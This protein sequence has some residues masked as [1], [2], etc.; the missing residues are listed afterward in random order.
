MN[1]IF[2]VLLFL[3]FSY[4][5]EAQFNLKYREATIFFRDGTQKKGLGKLAKLGSKIKFKET[6]KGEVIIY[7]Y[8]KLS[9][10]TIE[11]SYNPIEFEYKII[12]GKTGV[13]LLRVKKRG[14]LDLYYIIGRTPVMGGADGIT[15]G[16]ESYDI[17]YI[18]KSNDS[19]VYPTDVSKKKFKKLIDIFFKDCPKLIA[20]I[21]NKE[22]K[23]HKI[24]EIVEFYN[25]K[26]K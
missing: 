20:K 15:Y 14:K 17:Y 24:V 5:T 23:R 25:S 22:L 1:R 21:E 11:Y 13:K 9:G 8:K 12:K 16:G 4:S 18:A 6:K 19:F 7:D 2:F 10:F 3:A 26:C